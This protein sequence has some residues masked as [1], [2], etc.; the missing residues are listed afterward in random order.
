[1][2]DCLRQRNVPYSLTLMYHIIDGLSIKI[3]IKIK[4]LPFFFFFSFFKIVNTHY[5]IMGKPIYTG[6]LSHLH[7]ITSDHHIA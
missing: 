5:S 7:I 6:V 3:K 1:M 4:I 2:F